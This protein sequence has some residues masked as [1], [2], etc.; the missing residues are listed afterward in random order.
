MLAR[1]DLAYPEAK[2]AIEYDGKAHFTDAR[3]RADRRRDLLLA[4]HGWYTMRL[5]HEQVYGDPAAT[6]TRVAALR[7]ARMPRSTPV[8]V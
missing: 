5:T 7:A 3:S 6:R 8:N 2:L 4:D 1:V